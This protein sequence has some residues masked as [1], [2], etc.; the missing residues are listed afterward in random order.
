MELLIF[1]LFDR[2]KIMAS[3]KRWSFDISAFPFPFDFEL[4]Q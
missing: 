2:N 3:R 4:V 1:S